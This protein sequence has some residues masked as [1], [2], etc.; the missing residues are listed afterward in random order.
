MISQSV[1]SYIDKRCREGK[2]NYSNLHFGG[3]ALI[4]I[5]DPAQLPPVNGSFLWSM[6]NQL[7]KESNSHG[8]GLYNLIDTILKLHSNPRLEKDEEEFNEIL[9]R[10]RNGHNTEN[11]CI[12]IREKC[13]FEKKTLYEIY[14]FTD[15][16]AIAVHNTNANFLEDNIKN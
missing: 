11:N 12:W 2:P 10:L 8:F 16:N 5:G 6:G 7:N 13:S 14:S 9:K 1:L 15:N 3:I 4:L